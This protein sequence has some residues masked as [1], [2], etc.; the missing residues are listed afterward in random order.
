M[1]GSGWQQLLVLLAALV[2]IATAIALVGLAM[3]H[4]SLR[5]LRIPAGADFATTLR[6]VPLSLV[7]ILDLLDFGLD[8]FAAPITWVVLTRYRLNALRNVAAV[9]DLI[10][11]TQ[12]IPTMTVAWLVVRGLGLGHPP[13]TGTIIDAESQDADY[14]VSRTGRR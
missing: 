3:L 5:W 13:Q 1:G 2:V 9:E 4:R 11:F 7:V 14:V 6:L 12:L 10:P 8:I